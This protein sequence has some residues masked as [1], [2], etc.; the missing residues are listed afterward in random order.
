[1]NTTKTVTSF[2][3]LTYRQ[4]NKTLR[5]QANNGF[6]SVDRNP[7]YMGVKLGRTITY[8]K[9]LENTAHKLKKRNSI[10]R[11]LAETKWDASQTVLQTLSVT[12][13][14]SVAEYCATVLVRS[15]HTK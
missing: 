8:R 15:S 10:I 9:H 6:L 13:N 3:H 7:E 4:A 5:L 12:F 11:K 1:M 14:Y 2:F